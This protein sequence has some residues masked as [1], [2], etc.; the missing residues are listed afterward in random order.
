MEL[1]QGY[2]TLTG[3]ALTKAVAGTPDQPS[4]VTKS[5]V[6]LCT[7]TESVFKSLEIDAS[8]AGSYGM[9][10]ADAKFKFVQD[11]KLT[12]NSIVVLVYC[13]MEQTYTS[14]NFKIMPEA[15]ALI[16]PGKTANFIATYG[17]TFVSTVT[18]GAEYMAAFVFYSE[19]LEQKLV[20]EASLG[21]KVNGGG[22]SLDASLSTKLQNAQSSA[23]VRMSLVQ[24][25]TGFS[26]GSVTLPTPDADAIIKFGLAFS[27]LKPD[28]PTTVSFGVT[29]YENAGVTSPGELRPVIANRRLFDGDGSPGNPGLALT[30]SRLSEVLNMTVQIKNLFDFYGHRDD[31]L[32]NRRAAII[33][34]MNTV[35]ANITALGDDPLGAHTF[36]PAMTYLWGAPQVD[37]QLMSITGGGTTSWNNPQAFA[38]VTQFQIFQY[39]RIKNMQIN[40]GDRIDMVTITYETQLPALDTYTVVHGSPGG[41][42]H[43][44]NLNPGEWINSFA[45]WQDSWA[46]NN[47]R[48]GTTAGQVFSPKTPGDNPLVN[49]Q[50]N[51]G[52]DFVVGFAGTASNNGG[53]VNDLDLQLLHLLPVKWIPWTDQLKFR[54]AA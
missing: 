21:F 37:F 23:K 47:L 26:G 35:R 50:G 39:I 45:Q 14:S 30:Y 49:W 41:A 43:Y 1:F 44:L 2:N 36:A 6:S 22:G 53:D 27:N 3:A 25:I 40:V 4:G 34:D 32:A 17:N 54:L 33:A 15:D 51:P 28:Q 8:V 10:S 13:S 20:V 48:I 31:D 29:G 9:F 11:M 16:A 46:L 7:D 12:T 38:D 18:K 52:N 24:T 19:T 5:M 42:P